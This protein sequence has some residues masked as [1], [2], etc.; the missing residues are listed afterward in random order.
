MHQ[1]DCAQLIVFHSPPPL[2]RADCAIKR[3]R[4]TKDTPNQTRRPTA[5][6]PVIPHA[7]HSNIAPRRIVLYFFPGLKRE[8][9]ESVLDFRCPHNIRNIS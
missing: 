6:N 9:S 3:R 7:S 1:R 4:C 5:A 8:D 2:C